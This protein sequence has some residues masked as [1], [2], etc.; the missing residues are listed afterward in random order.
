MPRLR[1]SIQVIP[2]FTTCFVI[3]NRE[4]FFATLGMGW[5]CAVG[6]S[7]PISFA[8]FIN[9]INDTT[10]I[11]YQISGQIPNARHQRRAQAA[12]YEMAAYL[13]VRCMPLLGGGA[14]AQLT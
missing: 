2:N 13:R 4:S 10:G 3:L 1:E 5:Q 9:E 8:S 11:Q 14:G 7:I 6:E 12:D